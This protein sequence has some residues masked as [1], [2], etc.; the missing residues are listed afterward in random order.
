[1]NFFDYCGIQYRKGYEKLNGLRKTFYY[2]HYLVHAADFL[3]D[4]GPA[5][6]AQMTLFFE[7]LMSLWK[8]VAGNNVIPEYTLADD[9]LIRIFPE[10]AFTPQGVDPVT[11]AALLRCMAEKSPTYKASFEE[12]CD[13]VTPVCICE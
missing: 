4:R 3:R 7:R 2:L 12:K 8:S 9:Q 1:M 13:A 10:I 11:H 5:R 6:Y